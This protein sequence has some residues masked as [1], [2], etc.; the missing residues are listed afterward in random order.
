MEPEVEKILATT[1]VIKLY[2]N[3]II[4]KDLIF[5]IY[6]LLLFLFFEL[7]VFHELLRPFED[8]G[9]GLLIIFLIFILKGRLPL[10]L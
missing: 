10:D 7:V 2:F 3:I 5:R 1:A 8:G 9:V 6:L 4:N